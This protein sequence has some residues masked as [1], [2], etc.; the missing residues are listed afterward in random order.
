M[1]VNARQVLLCCAVAGLAAWGGTVALV[2]W[3]SDF[4]PEQLR[5]DW[6]WLIIVPLVVAV[7]VA[8]ALGWMAWRVRRPLE[9]L[10]EQLS[11]V[12]HNPSRAGLNNG[13]LTEAQAEAL[14]PLCEEI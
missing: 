5:A 8:A 13:A 2:L 14:G 11:V 7:A 10:T 6:D 4:D 12:R 3:R 1:L 9:A